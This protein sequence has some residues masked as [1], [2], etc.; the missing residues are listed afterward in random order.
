MGKNCLTGNSEIIAPESRFRV[1][2]YPPMISPSLVALSL[3]GARRAPL[4]EIKGLQQSPSLR[5]GFPF[6]KRLPRLW[7]VRQ[8]G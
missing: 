8:T 3:A 6:S 4:I 2:D 5:R 7:A 1:A